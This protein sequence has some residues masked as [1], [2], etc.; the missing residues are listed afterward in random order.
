[1]KDVRRQAEN[2]FLVLLGSPLRTDAEMFAAA[3]NRSD[4][5]PT[6]QARRQF[7]VPPWQHLIALAKQREAE[8]CSASVPATPSPSERRA[9]EGGQSGAAPAPTR[10]DQPACSFGAYWNSERGQCVKI[11]E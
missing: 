7:E 6:A 5:W 10:K 2:Q 11:G 9:P 1:M 8:A 4:P 3:V